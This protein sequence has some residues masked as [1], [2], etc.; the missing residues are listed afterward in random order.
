MSHR[1]ITRATRFVVVGLLL[2]GTTPSFAGEADG[3]RSVVVIRSEQSGSWSDPRTWK[4]GKVPQAGESVLIRPGHRVEYDVDRDVVIRAIH[5]GGTLEFSRQKSTRLDCGLIKIQ[6]GEDVAE[7]GFDCTMHAEEPAT[8]DS[9]GALIVGTQDAPIP[10]EHRALIRLHHIPGMDA[11]SCPAIVCCGGRMDFHGAPMTRT[12]VKLGATAEPGTTEIQLAEKISGWE[13]GDRVLIPS[14]ERLYLFGEGRRLIPTVRDG[15][16]SEERAITAITDD[17]VTLDKPLRHSHRGSGEFRGEIANLSRNVVVE[18]ADP[19]G[20]RGHTMYHAGSSGSISYAEFRFLGKKDVLGRYSLHFHLCRDSMRGSSV[21]GASIHDSDNRWLT[22]HGTDYL[23]VR[24]CVGY[25]SIGH[26]FFLEDGTE[27]FNVFDRNLAVQARHGKSLPKQVL[28]FDENEGAGFWW[29]NSLNSFTRNVAAECDQYGYRFEA[30]KTAEFDP[31]LKVPQPDGSLASVDVRTLPFVRFD[32]NEAHTHRRFALNLGGIRHV[33]DEEDYRQVRP[34]DGGKG[35]LSRIQGG[36]VDGVGP[37]TRHPFV[38]RNFRVWNSQWVFHG[39]SPCVL[40]DGL[41]ALDC[42]YGI[43]K[44]RMDAHEYRHLKMEGIDTA[45]IFEPWGSSSVQENYFQFLD[46][47]VDDLPPTTVVTHFE[48]LNEKQLKL[49]GTTAD[50]RR[51]KAV[52]INGEDAVPLRDNYAEWEIVIDATDSPTEIIATAIDV[53][54]NQEGR[55]HRALWTPARGLQR[56]H[57]AKST[58]VLSTNND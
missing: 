31:T 7:G 17:R 55:A 12:W 14:T 51:V 56:A 5:L 21:I 27:V 53:A 29:S 11:N 3:Q 49:Q 18:S 47:E 32:D 6:S 4:G 42:T 52:K 43:F 54:G 58:N 23:I 38:I 57:D 19:A 40:I 16:H 48:R 34:K 20:I 15:T 35:D 9:A 36:H 25:N 45:E 39:G 22:V 13:T 24:D 30:V 2:C 33:S 1:R 26:G 8:V 44:T 46:V 10:R 28:P 50:N 41:N 37:D